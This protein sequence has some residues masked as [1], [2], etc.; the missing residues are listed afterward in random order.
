[1]K[2]LPI[3][4]LHINQIPTGLEN[5]RK[6][7]IQEFAQSIYTA[8]TT[9]PHFIVVDGCPP[10]KDPTNLFNLSIAISQ[11]RHFS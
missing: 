8:L 2:L 6:A 3:P 1:M 9:Y 7:A 10:I 5:G 4:T 11:K